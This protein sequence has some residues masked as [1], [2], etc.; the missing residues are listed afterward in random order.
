MSDG[1]TLRVISSSELKIEGVV[2]Y[3][4]SPMIAFCG[5]SRVILYVSHHRTRNA[6][7]VV[8]SFPRPFLKSSRFV[9]HESGYVSGAIVHYHCIGFCFALLKL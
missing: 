2:C 8:C 3:L 9:N 4:E 5:L 7:Y 1:W 6:L